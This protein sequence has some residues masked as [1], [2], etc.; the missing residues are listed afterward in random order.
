MRRDF[1]TKEARPADSANSE[2]CSFICEALIA[3][4]LFGGS[5][6]VG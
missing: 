2:R 5:T 3:E 6:F 1:F 4:L